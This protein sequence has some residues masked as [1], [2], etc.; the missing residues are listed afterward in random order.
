MLQPRQ[1]RN[2][3]L[4]R[5]VLCAAL[6]VA[7]ASVALA[8]SGNI[9][10]TH[11]YAWSNFGGYINFAPS[12]GG[13]T[14][15]SSGLSGY[16]WSA[17]DGWINL[18]PSQSGVKNDG[19]GTLSG[20]AWDA[21][22]G[23]VN[24]AGVTIDSNGQFHGQA[25]GVDI[26]GTSY[27]INFDCSSCSVVTSWRSSASAH[28]A[29]GAIAPYIPPHVPQPPANTPPPSAVPPSAGSP[30]SPGP[31]SFGGGYHYPPGFGMSSTSTTTLGRSGS[32]TL[33]GHPTPGSRPAGKRSFLSSLFSPIGSFFSSFWNKIYFGFIVLGVAAFLRLIL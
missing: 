7:G 11:K 18:S 14:V 20:F 1:L 26:Q 4:H 15:T 21:T 30:G 23:W 13:V 8:A 6:I 28:H 25:S 27:G 10:S 24:F 33:P 9:D 16:A 31:A 19:S 2:N 12:S 3:S 22:A 29:H 17:N 32:T 5:S